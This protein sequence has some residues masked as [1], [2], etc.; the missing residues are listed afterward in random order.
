M[1]PVHVVILLAA[2][3]LGGAVLM[4]VVH[5]GKPAV[6]EVV[7]VRAALPAP[8][9]VRQAAPPAVQPAAPETQPAPDVKPEPEKP[10]PMPPP[11][12][13]LSRPPRVHPAAPVTAAVP[14]R[15]IHPAPPAN[16]AQAARAPEPAGPPEP[17]SVSVT[18][19]VPLSPAIAPPPAAAPPAPV[20]PAPPQPP[21]EPFPQPHQV[22]LNAGMS[23]PVR[24]VDG[25]SSER[26]AAG[27]VFTATL[28][29]ALVA[30]GFAIA[31][32]GA[33]VEGRVIA[34]DRAKMG[35]PAALALELTTLHTSDGQAVPIETEG[36]F[37]HAD[38]P[39]VNGGAK[40]AGG[41]LIGAAIGALAGGGKGA[42][43]GAGIGGGA[44]VGDVLL[45]R[46][47]AELASESVMIFRLKNS[48]HLTEQLH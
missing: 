22:T 5:P 39:R 44:G 37:Q 24:L 4:K 38:P 8:P 28:D 41:A 45:T 16:P 14:R 47:K 23:L 20:I 15:T 7:P 40:I 17:P 10:S 11:Q 46:R 43:I 3:A 29:Q 34:V 36:Y 26:N 35:R 27:D 9:P 42:A 12:P 6:A 2:G 21:A 1:R 32:R 33:R 30:G 19:S 18:S 48:V 31:E 13:A 25:L